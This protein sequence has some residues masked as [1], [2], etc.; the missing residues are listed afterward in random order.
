[1][2]IATAQRV[3]PTPQVDVLV[4]GEN[5]PLLMRGVSAG[6]R[7][8][9]LTFSLTDS[10]LAVQVA[11]PQPGRP[12]AHRT[13]RAD[14]QHRRRSTSAPT[15]RSTRPSR[16]TVVAARVVSA[17]NS[18]PATCLPRPAAPGFW[19]I[20]VAERPDRA[21]RRQPTG[22]RVRRRPAH[23]A[24]HLRSRN[25][26]GH[27][28]RARWPPASLAWVVLALL[29][30]VAVEAWLAWRGLGV[31]RGQWRVAAGLR[32]LVAVLLLGAWLAPSIDR[33]S[34]RQATVFLLDRSASLGSTGTGAAEAWLKSALAKRPEDALSAV[35]VF[36]AESRLDRLLQASSVFDG[37]SVVIDS[38]ATDIASAIRLGSAVLPSDAKRRLVLISDGRA[39]AGNATAEATQLSVTGVPVDTH[40]IES[41]G[42][43]D[44]A[45]S[46][47]VVPRLARVGDRVTVTA[48][49][50][51]SRAGQATVTLRR[52]GSD[53]DS[54]V[55]T[56]QP[57]DNTITF[58]DVRVDQA[59]AVL[60]Y[61]VAVAAPGDVQPRNDQAFAAVPVQG[62]AKI[63]VVEGTAGEAATLDNALRR[64]WCGHRGGLPRPA[65]CRARS[66]DLHR[67]G[68]G[69]R[70]RRA[71]FRRAD[72]Q[73]V[74]R[75]PRSRP[76]PAHRGRAAQL[77]RGRLPGVTARR[78]SAR[79][80]ARSSIPSGGARSPKCSASTRPVRWPPVTAATARPRWAPTPPRVGSTR[81]TS[82]APPPSEPSSR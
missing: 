67:R 59:G 55:V 8:A 29:A 60:R 3:T 46:K 25:Q 78:S 13:H 43:A 26:A 19:V 79:W 68:A 72:R 74:H 15:S 33:G 6:R 64:R 49:V 66:G 80:T 70:Q 39:T 1:M 61:Q 56:L 10:N 41:G 35:V 65:P 27:P 47:I 16:A 52:D 18:P 54:K 51:A 50:E 73:P 31:S 62:P 11:F 37:A 58:Q 28:G 63:L 81:P 36:G 57:G 32:I 42:G 82:P 17:S 53:L 22:G 77:R 71:A 12:A 2:A 21:R 44:A 75:R 45:V 40:V 69:R 14:H 5:A 23:H 30:I 7:F 34:D 48:H 20:S 24:D 4:A 38:S 9:Y 76:R